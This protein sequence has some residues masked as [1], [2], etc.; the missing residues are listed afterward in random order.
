M[1]A[2]SVEARMK[3]A[4][5]AS[6]AFR[7][8]RRLS[9]SISDRACEFIARGRATDAGQQWQESRARSLVESL[10]PL[11]QRQWLGVGA[12]A[13]VSQLLTVEEAAEARQWFTHA[14]KP[15]P[16][17][18]QPQWYDLPGRTVIGG[19]T[20]VGKSVLAAATAVEVVNRVKQAGGK[21]RTGAR[22]L[23]YCAGSVALLDDYW[24]LLKAMGCDM[25][26]VAARYGEKQHQEHFHIQRTPDD[27]VVD[28][29]ADAPVVLV[30]QQWINALSLQADGVEVDGDGP[31]WSLADVLAFKGDIRAGI[32]DE[33]FTRHD[34]STRFSSASLGL[35]LQ[36]IE[37]NGLDQAADALVRS[38]ALVLQRVGRELLTRS[39]EARHSGA[40]LAS[41]VGAISDQESQ[42]L[43]R[44]AQWFAARKKKED[45]G[46]ALFMKQMIRLL[47]VMANKP[48]QVWAL[49]S[50][51]KSDQAT[52]CQPHL[53]V[54]PMVERLVI[55]DASYT[56]S[57][58][59]EADTSVQ[60]AS[61]MKD[62]AD[63]LDPKRF[64]DVVIHIAHGPYGRRTLTSNKEKRSRLISRQVQRI[65]A[66]VPE[67]QEFLVILFKQD[68]EPTE[69]TVSE[70]LLDAPESF[71]W[72]GLV[73][74][75]LAAQGVKDWRRR[76]QFI[77][78][79]QH[80]GRNCWRHIVH[81]FAIGVLQRDWDGD[82]RT[83]MAA[84]KDA[85]DQLNPLRDGQSWQQAVNG[86]IASAIQ[87]LTGRT[88]CRIT[89]VRKDAI[90][91]PEH[92]GYSGEAHLW[93]EMCEQGKGG[94]A[95]DIEGKSDLCAA[96]REGMSG[97]QIVQ[98]SSIFRASPTRDAAKAGC[99]WLASLP[100]E[101][102]EVTSKEVIAMLHQWM[103]EN[104]VEAATRT[105]YRAMDSMK[106]QALVDG[107]TIDGKKWLRPGVAPAD[108]ALDEV[109]GL[110]RAERIQ[111]D[112]V[113][114]LSE[115]IEQEVLRRVS[116]GDAD[117]SFASVKQAVLASYG[118][119]VS[120]STFSNH[121]RLA[122]ERLKAQRIGLNG[123]GKAAKRWVAA[124]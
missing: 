51:Q 5:D 98:E 8:A 115:L 102:T 46:I 101:K 96:I 84:N 120:S 112:A 10:M 117:L 60:M 13:L 12:Q 80:T 42:A 1:A 85:L 20:G 11:H 35:A 23:V 34:M 121:R 41:F 76:A 70:D 104:R 62:A 90:G 110:V 31:R 19:P 123:E 16:G 25:D 73:E 114:P 59:R 72:R 65:L 122:D 29:F 64:D 27:E 50:A 63:W 40:G 45:K 24:R 9:L 77:T 108:A 69:E 88:N 57:L 93:V 111:A 53:K 92:K 109:E 52:F 113:V 32:W 81:A 71:S 103:A 86:E 15:E 22:G 68:D 7:Q 100:A 56:V 47:L 2:V 37:L 33:A 3:Q 44:L 74:A 79:G 99:D 97:V 26:C 55:L 38:G 124:A 75:E 58:V 78:W 105:V 94:Q 119:E 91:R 82:I 61:G 66:H 116:A 107:W 14:V 83:E 39:E 106:L 17:Q 89:L 18:P 48:Q 43:G 87:Q 21:R 36:T 54:H 95:V 28:R 30:T 49:P 6:P 118:R 67:D 4:E